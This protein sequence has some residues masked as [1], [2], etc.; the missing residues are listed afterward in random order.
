VSD[1]KLDFVMLITSR[2]SQGYK[3]CAG[4]PG[5]WGYEEADVKTFNSWGVDV[6]FLVFEFPQLTVA[7][8]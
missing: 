4:Y 8:L 5:S 2:R 6:G 7:V 3:T 1:T